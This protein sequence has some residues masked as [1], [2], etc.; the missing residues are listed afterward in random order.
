MN[1]KTTKSLSHANLIGQRL[2]E[3]RKDNGWT[4]AHVASKTGISVGT[5]SKLEHGK[6]E[7]NFS[8]V[9]KLA[10][11]LD[12]PVTDLT[13]PSAVIASE[14]KSGMRSFT[15]GGQGTKFQASDMSYEVLCNDITHHNQGYLKCVVQLH[16]FDPSMPWH[17]H[18]GQEF[19]Y[20]L[21]G[22]IDLYTELY[23]PLRLNTGDSVLFDSS[24]GHHYVSVSDIDAEILIS[25]SLQGYHNVADLLRS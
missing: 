12:L 6:T 2:R 5:L 10:S 17:H 13:N 7:L 1:D 25:M 8:S 11:G 18:G 4:L 22:A 3:L 19:V 23:Q 16:E 9:N 20:V 21:K 24:M 15:L 14:V